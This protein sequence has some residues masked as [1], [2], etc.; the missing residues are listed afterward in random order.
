MF[1]SWKDKKDREQ[2]LQ[3]Y[4]AQIELDNQIDAAKQAMYEN[5]IWA[6]DV[7]K[8]T[9]S[10]F[11]SKQPVP[12]LSQPSLNKDDLKEALKAAVGDIK[13]MAT[14]AATEAIDNAIGKPAAIPVATKPTAIPVATKPEAIPIALTTDQVE[15]RA[16]GKIQQ[17][18]LQL[19]GLEDKGIELVDNNGDLMNGVAPAIFADKETVKIIAAQKSSIGFKIKT[20]N[21]QKVLSDERKQLVESE[22]INKVNWSNSLEHFERELDKLYPNRQKSHSIASNPSTEGSLH[23][24]D[25]EDIKT[26][27]EVVQDLSAKEKILGT[28]KFFNSTKKGKLYINPIDVSG[29][30]WDNY[31]IN[32]DGTLTKQGFGVRALN[33]DNIDWDETY[34]KNVKPQEDNMNRKQKGFLYASLINQFRAFTL[35]SDSG[36]N[37]SM[38]DIDSER[39]SISSDVPMAGVGFSKRIRTGLRGGSRATMGTLNREFLYRPMGSKFVSLK[40]LG[41]GFLSLKHPSGG[42]VGKRVA[43]SNDAMEVI[44][45]Y[46]FDNHFSMDKYEQLN[47]QDKELIYD[48]LKVCKL[49]P[50]FRHP[51]KNPYENKN[52]EFELDKLLG[53][54][55]LGN[56]NP[57]NK[58]ELRRLA[59]YM[60]ENNLLSQSKIRELMP[61][62]V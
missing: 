57:R 23:L 52:Y 26:L 43:L 13:T 62:L 11:P 46:I 58:E 44:K 19:E 60:V 12:S 16:K 7:D 18:L 24:S 47:R 53:E 4:I 45:D 9:I 10:S 8:K 30:M 14:E 37:K 38:S 32:E 20:V 2:K 50:T 6:S 31:T 33:P 61:L 51:L 35:T 42:A 1:P 48:V 34:K 27:E 3:A 15:A 36:S 21:K 39:G 59:S 49:L 5:T 22:R 54:L 56:N 55:R 25:L 40:A 28:I 17:Y 41:E 29:T